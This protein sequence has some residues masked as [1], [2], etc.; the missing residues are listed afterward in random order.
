MWLYLLLYSKD[1]R[2]NGI[3]SCFSWISTTCFVLLFADLLSM[4]KNISIFPV[5]KNNEGLLA[6][7]LDLS[8]LLNAIKGL[9]HNLPMHA[10]VN[11]D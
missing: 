4:K 3:I 5:L 7:F 9:V 10:L 11:L 1:K 6:I 8:L 2:N